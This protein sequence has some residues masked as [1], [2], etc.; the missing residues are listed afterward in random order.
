LTLRPFFDEWYPRLVR[1]LRAKVHDTDVAED[2][3]QEAF[4]RLL[5]HSPRSPAVWLFS[6]ANNLVVDQA[7]SARGRSRCMSLIQADQ[8]AAADPGPEQPLLRAETVWRVRRALAALSPRD[9]E[10][11]LLHHDGWRYRDLAARFGVAPSSIGSL[12]TRAQRRFAFSY[13]EM[14]D[15][16]ERTSLRRNAES[17]R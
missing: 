6:V 1:Y 12:L 7:R 17:A 2:I 3:A 13:A 16:D 11:L 10:L 14:S 8:C 15:H 4:V 9:Q 5:D